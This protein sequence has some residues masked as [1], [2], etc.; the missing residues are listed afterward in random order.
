MLEAYLVG[1]ALWALVYG[2]RRAG[3][4][5][6]AQRLLA[7]CLA[8]PLILLA[9]FASAFRETYADAMKHRGE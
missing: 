4:D 5:G 3:D 7:N 8:W 9:A 2:Y 6:D 1:V